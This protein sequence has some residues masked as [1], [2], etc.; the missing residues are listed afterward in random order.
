MLHSDQHYVAG[1]RATEERLSKQVNG[2]AAS[3]HGCEEADDK[4]GIS[5]GC[6]V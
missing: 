2:N 4:E 5:L 3:K 6:K 1:Q